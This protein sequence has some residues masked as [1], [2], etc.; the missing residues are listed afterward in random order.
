MLDDATKGQGDKQHLVVAITNEYVKNKNKR[1]KGIRED[2]NQLY[3][4]FGG[5]SF[6]L[7]KSEDSS[8][9][10]MELLLIS[11]TREAITQRGT[12]QYKSAFIIFSGHGGM[13][14]NDNSFIES[15]FGERVNLERLIEDFETTIG[16]DVPKFFLI[17]ACRNVVKDG[18]SKGARDNTLHAYATK[19]GTTAGMYTTT[20][21]HWIQKVL[22]LLQLSN[23]D[24][25]VVEIIEEANKKVKDDT[26]QEP[27]IQINTLTVEGRNLCLKI[28]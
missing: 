24:K 14:D 27:V 3:K 22:K 5:E 20:G 11:M 28:G 25:T 19:K 15:E 21:S 12:N 18:I 7:L 2:R 6:D 13:T 16:A 23:G 26:G 17:D 1:L 9:R 4:T 10:K 8:K